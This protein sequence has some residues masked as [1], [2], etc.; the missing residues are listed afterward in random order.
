MNARVLVS[1]AVRFFA[2]Y[3]LVECVETVA[4][5]VLYAGMFYSVGGTSEKS[6]F[7][8]IM[9][10]LVCSLLVAGFLLARTDRVAGWVLRG[11]ATGEGTVSF[12]AR[13]L[14]AITFYVAGLVFLV[15]GLER[16]LGQAVG[17]YL[18]EH[19][20]IGG[21]MMRVNVPTL[22]AAGVRV[23]AGIGLLLAARR[24]GRAADR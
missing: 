7:V 14:A 13:E 6:T 18:R 9:I 3:L 12:T 2:L 19:G 22:V 8:S 16:L 23:I 11:Q 10:N 15:S 20:A 1:A 21:I 4:D 24:Q 17:S 5:A